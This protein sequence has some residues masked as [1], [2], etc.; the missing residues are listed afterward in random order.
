[1]TKFY[2]Y[3]D[4]T[5]TTT[6]YQSILSLM[7]YS[8]S[9]TRSQAGKPSSKRPKSAITVKNPKKC[10]KVQNQ[11]KSKFIKRKPNNKS[12]EN[13]GLTPGLDDLPSQDRSA[14][15]RLLIEFPFNQFFINFVCFIRDKLLSYFEV[16]SEEH[17]NKVVS[18]KKD[19]RN[20]REHFLDFEANM[21]SKVS[22]LRDMCQTDCAH[23]NQFMLNVILKWVPREANAQ[24]LRAPDLPNVVFDAKRTDAEEN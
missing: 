2:N 14:S 12:G 20:M 11:L 22:I 17:P 18:S 4:T 9:G 24:L 5:V 1:M 21:E 19:L 3:S 6:A 13:C 8:H 10:K 23:F 15:L 7:F 16:F